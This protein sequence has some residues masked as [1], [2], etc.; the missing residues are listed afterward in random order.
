MTTS[1]AIR[2]SATEQDGGNYVYMESLEKLRFHLKK[3]SIDEGVEA[4]DEQ[5]S[6]D[7]RKLRDKRRKTMGVT[8]EPEHYRVSSLKTRKRKCESANKK[9]S[10]Q[11]SRLV[12]F[13]TTKSQKKIQG[14][15]P[16]NPHQVIWKIRKRE[17]RVKA[18]DRF[19]CQSQRMDESEWSE[20]E[21]KPRR[22][23][24]KRCSKKIFTIQLA[25]LPVQTLISPE[26]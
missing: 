12:G 15:F 24:R 7:E 17:I 1:D 11:F 3:V 10:Y 22:K 26:N 8:L 19:L 4:D 13:H 2:N 9:T 21:T 25:S 6:E 23:K 20:V 16:R 5:D 14:T 18:E